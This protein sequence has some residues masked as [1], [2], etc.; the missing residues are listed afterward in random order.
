MGL[1]EL[2][3]M[4]DRIYNPKWDTQE[5]I[6]MC[7]AYDKKYGADIKYLPTSWIDIVGPVLDDLVDAFPEMKFVQVKEKMGCIRIYLDPRQAELEQAL[8]TIVSFPLISRDVYAVR[9]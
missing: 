7:A 4:N 3:E 5:R 9:P 2:T 1:K 8:E 6:D